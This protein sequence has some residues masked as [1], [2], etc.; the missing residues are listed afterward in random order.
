MNVQIKAKHFKNA[1][2]HNQLDCALARATRDA[3]GCNNVSEGVIASVVDERYVYE[4]APYSKKDF[5]FDSTI[6]AILRFFGLYNWTV[7]T[8]KFTPYNPPQFPSFKI[9]LDGAE[10]EIVNGEIT[11]VI[12]ST[13]AE[14][15]VTALIDDDPEDEPDYNEAPEYTEEEFYEEPDGYTIEEDESEEIYDPEEELE[16]MP[17][18]PDLDTYPDIEEEELPDPVSE[19]ELIG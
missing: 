3:T 18:D 9:L 1:D 19:P 6:A 17:F 10:C 5:E 15:N 2:F 11:R 8:V 7:R 13:S 14:L 12:R 4:H 16:S